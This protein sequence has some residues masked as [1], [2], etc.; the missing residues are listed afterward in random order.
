M[1]SPKKRFS[2]LFVGSQ[3]E[4]AGAQRVLLSQARWFHERGHEVRAVF[5]YD[6]EKLLDKWQIENPFP[7]I[8]LDAWR[9]GAFPLLNYLR[10]FGGLL[11][12]RK[13]MRKKVEAVVSFTP[14]SN[15]L[16]MPLARLAGVPVRIATHHGYIEGSSIWLARTHGWM[17]NSAL[18][19]KV[20]AVSE[21]VSNYAKQREKIRAQKLKVIEN[22]IESLELNSLSDDD[23]RV[24]RKELAVSDGGQL[25]LTVG[26]LTV[27]KGHSVL[28]KAIARIAADFPKAIFVFAG[29]GKQRE[30]LVQEASTLGIS[31]QIRFLGVRKDVARLLLASDVFVQPSLWEGLSLAMLEALLSGTPVLATEVEGVIDVIKNNEN[32][33]LVTVDDPA[34]LVTAISRLLNDKDLRTKLGRAGNVHVKT[35]YGIDTMCKQYLE[36]MQQLWLRNEL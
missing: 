11:R 2:I 14:H 5:F 33:L 17:M 36:L 21:Q 27:Q 18:A 15:V 1:Q 29:E 28:L 24:V 3:M 35:H 22:G 13:L 8:S 34:A 20:V 6:K 4:V 23:R 31:D 10:L 12:L 7:V 19:S 16:A 32:G 9:F 30:K 25:L 26:R